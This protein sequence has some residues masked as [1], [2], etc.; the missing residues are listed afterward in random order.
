LTIC[1]Q[2]EFPAFEPLAEGELFPSCSVSDTER[3]VTNNP[4]RLSARY[5]EATASLS[6]ITGD[7][8][9]PNSN[10]V[11]KVVE[12][13]ESKKKTKNTTD[14]AN[15]NSGSFL[16][17]LT[18]ADISNVAKQKPRLFEYEHVFFVGDLNYRLACT[19]LHAITEA[20]MTND[21]DWLVSHD[22]LLQEKA[23]GNIFEGFREADIYFLPTYKYRVGSTDYEYFKGSKKPAN[24]GAKKA[25]EAKARLPKKRENNGKAGELGFTIQ[26]LRQLNLDSLEGEALASKFCEVAARRSGEKKIRFSTLSGVFSGDEVCAELVRVGVVADIAS[27][28]KA[29]NMLLSKGFFKSCTGELTFMENGC[30]RFAKVPG[31]DLLP[32]VLTSHP[33]QS[34]YEAR[35]MQAAV[36]MNYDLADELS[37]KLDLFNAAFSVR[38]AQKT[39]ER[40]KNLINLRSS[41]LLPQGYAE[42]KAKELSD[43]Q[44]K[45][46]EIAPPVLLARPASTTYANTAPDPT[47][48]SLANLASTHPPRVAP[49][50]P[51]PPPPRSKGPEPASP[52]S[53]G[54]MNPARKEDVAAG[55]KSPVEDDSPASL[56]KY[57]VAKKHLLDEPH[58]APTL[59]P[60]PPP[61][62]RRSHGHVSATD[63]APN[64]DDEAPEDSEGD[65]DDDGPPA[66]GPL[67]QISQAAKSAVRRGAI[68]CFTDPG[69]VWSLPI[70]RP[71]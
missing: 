20:I 53:R 35:I 43:K 45:E 21:L 3:D 10:V 47:S 25:G 48:A 59:G 70:W 8:N 22:Q 55:P 57:F 66:D 2:I 49:P 5:S 29:G 19:D 52:T 38:I 12:R 7:A 56:M 1:D 28:L 27:A 36:E 71:C 40:L 4:N 64:G 24:A 42:R 11:E 26:M 60:D 9:T 69:R 13:Q 54:S 68:A 17:D 65:D 15:D 31:E 18:V 23:K 30:Y 32:A 33:K 41:V 39:N 51:P 62:V 37:K 46:S 61:S 16:W 58:C 44:R 63:S 14:L 50:P 6:D 34:E 67:L